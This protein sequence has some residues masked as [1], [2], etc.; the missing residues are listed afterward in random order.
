M[1]KSDDART[2]RR[3]QTVCL[4]ILCMIAVGAAL[5]LLR[6]VLVPF[7]LAI[8]L[9]YCLIP[10]ID[11]Q[12]KYL[13]LPWTAAIATSL[14]LAVAARTLCGAL[15]ASSVADATTKMPEYQVQFQQLTGRL[16]RATPLDRLGVEINP[17]NI[18]EFL[19]EQENIGWQFLSG[20]LGEAANLLSNGTLVMIFML[21]LL[22][23]RKPNRTS[24]SGLLVDIEAGV[25]RYV[26]S[27]I[28]LSAVTGFLVGLTLSLLGVEFAWV[29]GLLAFLLNFVPS[30][31]AI[32]ASLL[33]LPV[34]LL[35]PDLSVAAQV[36][37]IA[38]PAVI[39]FV[40][41]NFIQPR[42][43]GNALDL[44]PVTILL[45]LIFFGMIWGLIGAFLATPIA[46]VIRII[47][48]RIPITRPLACILAGRL[49][50]LTE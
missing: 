12:R 20:A 34:V 37:A 38:V 45:A 3:V 31:G 24:A 19:A 35:N 27:T 44:H 5:F 29:F 33:P 43:Q 26:T 4:V 11:V 46:A 39:Q 6:P 42:V 17:E 18:R 16:I 50:A 40:I 49:G 47:L 2:D 1:S 30:I 23:G 22:L 41:G 28:V 8:F 14:L 21:L 36:S 9:T 48:E 13:R 25:K 15:I 10:L 32:I 7:V